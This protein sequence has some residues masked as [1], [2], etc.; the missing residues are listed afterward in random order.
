MEFEVA[1]DEFAHAGAEIGGG[2]GIKTEAWD[3]G[4]GRVV[5]VEKRNPRKQGEEAKGCYISD[6]ARGDSS[7]GGSCM[8]GD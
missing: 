1:V 4:G 7:F 3:I 8:D 2:G 6:E 5:G